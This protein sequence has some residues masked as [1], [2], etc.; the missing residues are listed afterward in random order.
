MALIPVIFS[1]CMKSEAE[2]FGYKGEDLLNQTNLVYLVLSSTVTNWVPERVLS[3]AEEYDFTSDELNVLKAADLLMPGEEYAT[4]PEAYTCTMKE[5]WFEQWTKPSKSFGFEGVSGIQV[6]H[7]QDR[8]VFETS[9][10]YFSSYW[11]TKEEALAAL[12]TIEAE[13]AK[14]FNVKKFHKISDGW[15]AEYVRLCVMGVVGQKADGSWSC[16]LDVRDKGRVG[17]GPYEPVADQ[18]ERLNRYL[19]MKE[20]KVWQAEVAAI[21]AKNADAVAKLAAEKGVVGFVDAANLTEYNNGGRKIRVLESVDSLPEGVAADAAI[22]G[23]WTNK[24]QSIVKALGVEFDGEP[25]K[26]CAGENAWEQWWSA[27]WKNDLYDV[28]LDVS[29]QMAETDPEKAADVKSEPIGRVR[30][31]YTEAIQP[32]TVFPP[33]PQMKQP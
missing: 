12:A 28:R 32:G 22:A 21:L 17:C 9:E 11:K 25:N 16:M 13:L 23:L 1:G 6:H 33:R 30:I 19:Y 26:E 14:N 5:P 8:R 24:V 3:I 18:Q 31:A 29:I 2:R 4:L 27:E 7:N 20:M 10:S 15:V